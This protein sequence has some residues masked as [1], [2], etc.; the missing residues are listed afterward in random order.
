MTVLANVHLNVDGLISTM[1]MRVVFRRMA[2][3]LAEL[4]CKF[5]AWT[6]ILCTIS[7]V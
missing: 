6:G 4:W 2:R 7:V 5:R 3:C 1:C